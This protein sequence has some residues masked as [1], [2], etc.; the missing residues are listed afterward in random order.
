MTILQVSSQAHTLDNNYISYDDLP[1]DVRDTTGVLDFIGNTPANHENA[2][3]VSGDL[4]VQVS[5]DQI[6]KCTRR[7][8]FTHAALSLGAASTVEILLGAAGVSSP[9]GA[10]PWSGWRALP[11]GRALL[12]DLMS[13]TTSKRTAMQNNRTSRPNLVA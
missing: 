12:P 8:C 9:G 13:A 3:G 11:E 10:S 1:R 6:H 7:K 4:Q 5:V 2:S